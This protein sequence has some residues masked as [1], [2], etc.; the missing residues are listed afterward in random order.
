MRPY[1]CLQRHLK[2]LF[3][4]ALSLLLLRLKLHVCEVG[5]ARW[6][7]SRR[8]VGGVVGGGGGG[9]EMEVEMEVRWRW[10]WSSSN[11]LKLRLLSRT[12][13]GVSY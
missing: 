10:S 1:S 3:C 13:C 7:S 4:G 2:L 12:S 9:G 11:N 6:R 5:G 8:G